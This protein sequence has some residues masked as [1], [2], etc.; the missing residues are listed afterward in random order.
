M[1][2]SVGELPSVLFVTGTDT[3][4]GKTIVTAALAAALTAN[5][6]SV[7]VYK[8]T[9]AGLEDGDGDIDVVRRLA[10]V[11][12]AEGI[13]L[14]DPM[15][16]VAS[17]RRAGLTLPSLPEHVAAIR[18]LAASHDHTLVEG[19]G[20]VLVALTDDGS[21]LVDIASAVAEAAAIIVCRSGL[22]TLNHTE[23]TIEALI[24]RGV[25]IAGVVIGSWPAAPSDIDLSN[26]EYLS[27]HTVQLLGAVPARAGTLDSAAFGEASSG[28]F[29]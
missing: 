14:P 1:T 4:V 2:N 24:G 25:P 3:G 11:E 26:R 17:A 22:G 23:L 6:R 10:G 18:A 21:T 28:W 12:G 13:R 19:A 8:P 7:T 9:Q 29:A 15:A 5:G 27:A 20:G 16:P